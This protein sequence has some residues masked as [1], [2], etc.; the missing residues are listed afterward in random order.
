MRSMDEKLFDKMKPEFKEPEFEI[1]TST[2]RLSEVV[3]WVTNGSYAADSAS[4][5]DLVR[6]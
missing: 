1:V 5:S 3:S 6:R 2:S 4:S